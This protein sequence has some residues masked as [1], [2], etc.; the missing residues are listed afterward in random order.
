MNARPTSLSLVLTA[1]GAALLAWWLFAIARHDVRT[2][3]TVLS[4]LAVAA[5]VARAVSAALGARRFVLCLAGIAVGAGALAAAATDGTAV[6][7]AAVCLL[8]VTADEIVPLPAAI[9][10]TLAAIL[11]AALGVVLAPVPVPVV[12]SIVG[13]LVLCC[14]GGFSRRQVRDAQRRA[15]LLHERE[16]AARA[17]AG[18]VA[19]ARDLHD[20][21]AHTLGG[22]A[23][24]LDAAD[25]LLEAGDA[26]SARPRVSSARDLA[27]AGLDEARR[28]VAA[29]RE[30]H[31]G[32]AADVAADALA[33]RLSEL[34]RVHESLGGRASWRATG[35]AVPVPASVAAALEH[36]LQEA[37]SNVR[38]HAPGVVAEAWLDWADGAVSLAV[39]NPL[40]TPGLRAPGGGFGLIGMRERFAALPGG[41]LDAGIREGRFVV[42]VRTGLAAP[43]REGEASS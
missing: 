22:L 39:A 7:P 12:L 17:E 2:W 13:V 24:Q 38:R 5:W 23:I 43:A 15:Q 8:A 21:L 16:V 19:L 29:L 41:H 26:A 4:A 20:V 11:V 30:P 25:A 18:R 37:L 35:S 32:Q 42:C 36:A 31:A 27:A 1:V 33:A 6:I 14:L 40:A 34:L 10:A 3:A 9:G 28:A